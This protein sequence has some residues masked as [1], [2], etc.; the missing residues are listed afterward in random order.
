[1][2]TAHYNLG[3]AHAK[4]G[5]YLATIESYKQAIR[6]RPDLAEVHNNLG[7]NYLMT[8]DKGSALEEYKILKTLDAELANKLFH[9]IYE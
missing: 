3:V 4:L 5:R 7:N 1:M 9:L 8:G 6:I 2:A